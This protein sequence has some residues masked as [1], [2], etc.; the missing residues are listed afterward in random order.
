MKRIF[1]IAL[2]VCAIFVSC[3]NTNSSTVGTYD[4]EGYTEKENMDKN[5]EPIFEKD[6]AN[7]QID[8]RKEH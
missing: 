6:S 7:H 5:D 8:T 1:S 3:D 4:E 2:I